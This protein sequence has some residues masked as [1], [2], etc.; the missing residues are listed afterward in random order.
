ME[1][2]FRVI[3]LVEESPGS[4]VG[5]I[6]R[7]FAKSRGDALLDALCFYVTTGANLNTVKKTSVTEMPDTNTL[8]GLH[9]V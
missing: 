8:L 1:K 9:A 6:H 7:V 4:F 5:R 3:L 2:K